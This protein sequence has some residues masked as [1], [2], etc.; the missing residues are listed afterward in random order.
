MNVSI[1]WVVVGS[2]VWELNQP[3]SDLSVYKVNNNKGSYCGRN[4]RQEDLI[5]FYL[6][7]SAWQSEGLTT[8]L[9][10]ERWLCIFFGFRMTCTFCGWQLCC[11]WFE[12]LASRSKLRYPWL[13]LLWLLIIWM[14]CLG[15]SMHGGQP[16]G[17]MLY[18]MCYQG[19]RCFKR[20]VGMSLWLCSSRYCTGL[21]PID[22]K[23]RNTVLSASNSKWTI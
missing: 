4:G 6:K 23:E 1:S 17:Y 10:V 14:G 7:V 11:V 5:N 8:R 15:L 19:V 21:L 9:I 13:V 22:L 20:Y 12:G 2:V 18:G 3:L 16:N